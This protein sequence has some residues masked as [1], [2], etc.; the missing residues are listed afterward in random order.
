M[1]PARPDNF[2][3]LP[4]AEQ[5]AILLK[6]REAVAAQHGLTWEQYSQIPAETR[7]QMELAVQGY[8]YLSGSDDMLAAAKKDVRNASIS[9]YWKGMTG[10]GRIVLVAA[11][12]AAVWLFLPQIKALPKTLRKAVS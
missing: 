3:S 9:A 2:Y 10:A 12:V 5:T 8:T 11:A 7:V 6:E 1:I 4:E